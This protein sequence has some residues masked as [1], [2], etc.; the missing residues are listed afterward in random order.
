MR[1]STVAVPQN[2]KL[3]VSL[4][5]CWLFRLR[6]R[7]TLSQNATC[8][9]AFCAARSWH[10]PGPN[11]GKRYPSTVSLPSLPPHAHARLSS[12]FIVDPCPIYY[13]SL[14]CPARR[15]HRS[16]L[17]T[18]ALRLLLRTLVALPVLP[19]PTP[20][21]LP[22]LPTCTRLPLSILP[23]LCPYW[24]PHTSS[25]SPFTTTSDNNAPFDTQRLQCGN[26][27][28]TTLPKPTLPT[29]HSVVPY[30]SL[31]PAPRLLT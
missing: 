4:P 23:S 26:S 18:Y 8:L 11:D 5:V 2:L 1:A 10:I 20:S 22:S 9:S 17:I 12:Q 21:N 31:T 25:S 16:S 28:T 3:T 7:W 19:P 15:H 30:L 13:H 27:P 24:L 29:I 14:P 6:Q